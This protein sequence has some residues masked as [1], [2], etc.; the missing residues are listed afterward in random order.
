MLAASTEQMGGV[1]AGGGS[2]KNNNVYP[3]HVHT[4]SH[5]PEG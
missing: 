5:L 1:D 4:N 2:R 3:T